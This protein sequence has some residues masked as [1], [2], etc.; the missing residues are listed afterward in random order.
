MTALD[1]PC[2]IAPGARPGRYRHVKVD[3]RSTSAHRVAWERAHGPIPPGMWVLHHC[4]NPPCD[5]ESHLFLGDHAANVAD[6][7]AKRRQAKGERH[8]NAKLTAARVRAMRSRYAAGGI[9]IT[10]LA[11]AFDVATPAI[12]RAL[13]GTTWA[14]V[15]GPIHTPRR[16]WQSQPDPH[17]DGDSAHVESPTSPRVGAT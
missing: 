14:H 4:D 5:E 8:G 2:R 11:A 17:V 9:T 3:G 7:D 15:G 12:W 13:I 6:R 10:R 16:H 1:T